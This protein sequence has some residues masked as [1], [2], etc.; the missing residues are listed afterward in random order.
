MEN[1]YQYP[2]LKIIILSSCIFIFIKNLPEKKE[3]ESQIMVENKILSSIDSKIFKN[4]KNEIEFK[5]EKRTK[6]LEQESLKDWVDFNK[7]ENLI[8]IDNKPYYFFIFKSISDD[9]NLF[10]V[11]A[12]H[13]KKFINMTWNDIYDQQQNNFLFMKEKT[14]EKLI[15]QMYFLSKKKKND[16]I[17][18]RYY[19]TD[20]IKN[21]ITLKES[22]IKYWEKDGESG[23]IGSGYTLMNLSDNIKITYKDYT[24]HLSSFVYIFMT[25]FTSIFLLKRNIILSLTFLIVSLFSYIKYENSEEYVGSNDTEMEKNNS[26]NSMLLSLSFLVGVNVFIIKSIQQRTSY[27][28]EHFQEIIVLFTCSVS[29]ILISII[30]FSSPNDVDE[31]MSY[32]ISKQLIFNLAVF[33][34]I[35][36]IFTYFLHSTSSDQKKIVK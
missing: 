9:K 19:W 27:K 30:N 2:F 12:H 6:L 15:E 14:N 25:G 11:L 17:V 31:L 34:N 36:I 16:V 7:K 32:R 35:V 21:E 33:I 28:P 22:I 13:K 10:Q 24:Y 20:P 8:Y 5:L 1:S 29:L 4:I 3:K 23:I 26:I 18:L